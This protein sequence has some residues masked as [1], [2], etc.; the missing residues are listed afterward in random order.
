MTLDPIIYIKIFV[1]MIVFGTICK[2]IKYIMWMVSTLMRLWSLII[3]QIYLLYV[4][5]RYGSV[6]LRTKN[7]LVTGASTYESIGY[8]IAQRLIRRDVNVMI[9]GRSIQGLNDSWEHLMKYKKEIGSRS[10]IYRHAADMKNKE[11]IITLAKVAK[12]KFNAGVDILINNHAAF[13]ISNFA[14]MDIDTIEEIVC[15]NVTGTCILTKRL[16]DDMLKAKSGFVVNVLSSVALGY[17][18]GISM[19]SSTKSGL[20]TFSHILELELAGSGVQVSSVYPA[21]VDS[22]TGQISRLYVSLKRRPQT[23]ISSTTSGNVA[24]GVLNCI[25]YGL[26]E[27]HTNYIN[28]VLLKIMYGFGIYRLIMKWNLHK[29]V[30]S[31]YSFKRVADLKDMTKNLEW[32][33]RKKYVERWKNFFTKTQ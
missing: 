14:D 25:E 24:D 23:I 8:C 20:E 9:T 30:S 33:E 26:S 2:I 18:P 15:S 32:G 31:V 4:E 11:E 3:E 27:Y 5:I 12:E 16:L 6:K 7:A 10:K 13:A 22:P 1:R 29:V 28:D 19:Y 17:I 21:V